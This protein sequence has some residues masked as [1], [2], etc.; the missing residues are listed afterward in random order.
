MEDKL[1]VHISG[2]S[3]SGKSTLGNKL[4]EHFKD[5]IIVKDLDELLDDYFAVHFGTDSTHNLGDINEESYQEYINNYISEQTKPI[6]FVGLNDNFVDFYPTR[7]DIY[8]DVYAKYKY[9]IDIGDDIIIKQKCMRFLENVKNDANMM[10]KIINDNE[11]FIDEMIIAV[12]TE[13][14]REFIMKWNNK[15]KYYYRSHWYR[16]MDRDEIYEDVTNILQRA[17][18]EGGRKKSKKNVRKYK[19]RKT[20]RK[21]KKKI[22]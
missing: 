20:Q 14:N 18:T 19:R 12:N 1:I 7:K 9:Y 3:G 17:L 6:V 13:C 8:Y 4:K 21:Y 22:A 15:W 16:F 5:K 10:D 2:P 11:K